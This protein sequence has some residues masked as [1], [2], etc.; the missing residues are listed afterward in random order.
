MARIRT[1][2]P[3]LFKH[4]ALFDAESET[5]LPLR[6]AFIGLFTCCDRAGRFKWRSRTL[7]LDVL[8]Y[9]NCDFS[10]VLDALCTR[11]FLVRYEVDGEEFGCI[12]TFTEHQAINNREVESS[13][14]PPD[15]SSIKSCTSTREAR[16]NDATGTPAEGKGKEGKGKEYSVPNGT[17]GEPA[18]KTPEEMTKDELWRAGKSLL[19]QAGMPIAQCGSFVGKLVKDYGN[20]AVVQAVRTAVVERPADPASFLRA[21]C[22]RLAGERAAPKRP[23]GRPSIND[24][25]D[26][27]DP[28]AGMKTKL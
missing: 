10:R 16:V 27:D 18:A 28:F 26:G 11:G 8:P 24:F 4:E 25:S 6:L 1:V 23:P 3:E 17:A 22:Q 12:P 21:T 5:G 7:K 19:N 14:P 20:D 9:D 13:I 15:E 2:K